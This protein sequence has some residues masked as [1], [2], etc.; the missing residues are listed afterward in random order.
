MEVSREMPIVNY[1]WWGIFQIS[2]KSEEDDE[3]DVK[4]N[5]GRKSLNIYY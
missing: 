2:L 3:G 1:E 5:C 4:S